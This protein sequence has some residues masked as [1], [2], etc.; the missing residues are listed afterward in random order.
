VGSLI[1]NCSQPWRHI[2][3]A[4]IVIP[5]SSLS[6]D[7]TPTMAEDGGMAHGGPAPG[8]DVPP[9]MH[10]HTT[11]DNESTKRRPSG[12]AHHDDEPLSPGM[13]TPKPF[14]RAQTSLD[15]DDYFVRRERAPFAPGLP[16]LTFS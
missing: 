16:S 10:H 5:Y 2:F 15:L 6:Q 9:A 14:S 11:D 1:V 13:R 8:T 12:L 7:G 4:T 3:N